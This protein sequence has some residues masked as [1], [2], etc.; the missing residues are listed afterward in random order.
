M[1]KKQVK[2]YTLDSAMDAFN[3]ESE[4]GIA[5]R[6]MPVPDREIA[7][8]RLN[9]G[10]LDGVKAAVKAKVVSTKYSEVVCKQM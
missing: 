4:F 10:A 5:L 9:K 6:A 1:N 2:T 3:D 8:A 7:V